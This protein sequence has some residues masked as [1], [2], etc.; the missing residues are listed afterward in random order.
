M[1]LPRAPSKRG[2][3]QGGRPVG[4]A[5]RF[6]PKAG[7][8]PAVE[9][10]VEAGLEEGRAADRATS[11]LELP[12]GGGS[13]ERNIQRMPE[14]VSEGVFG[15]REPLGRQR[16]QI[17]NRTSQGNVL[18]DSF[19]RE[20]RTPTGAWEALSTPE[21]VPVASSLRRLS[22]QAIDASSQATLAVT[23]KLAPQVDKF[24]I[25]VNL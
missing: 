11:M 1:P 17:K 16:R 15:V 6:T 23:G 25:D 3:Q 22:S 9:A 18:A 13:G 8:R 4:C 10:L 24:C 21:S 2:P 19:L 7:D 20:Q 5:A 12:L 14:A